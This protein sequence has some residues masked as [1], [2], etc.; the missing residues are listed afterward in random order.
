MKQNENVC[1]RNSD[2]RFSGDTSEGPLNCLGG[3]SN[4]F[5]SEGCPIFCRNSVVCFQ[6]QI[7]F[8]LKTD[9]FTRIRL[10]HMRGS[11]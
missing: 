3:L 2:G 11:R 1:E 7:A 5:A 4:R 8:V 6:E 10:R 9:Y